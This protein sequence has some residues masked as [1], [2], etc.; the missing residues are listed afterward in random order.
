MSRRS[1]WMSEQTTRPYWQMPDR[2]VPYP[3][4]ARINM[5][6]SLCLLDPLLRNG[7]IL[8]QTGILTEKAMSSTT[9]PL[10]LQLAVTSLVEGPLSYPSNTTVALQCR[11]LT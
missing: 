5:M 1:E 6:M 7:S 10:L 9:G 3:A 11:S 2:I 4:P 8:T